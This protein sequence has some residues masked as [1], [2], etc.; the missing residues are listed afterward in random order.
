[1]S[2]NDP[3]DTMWAEACAMMERAERLHRQFFRPGSAAVAPATWEPP[4]DMFENEREVLI[5]AVLPGVAHQD[6]E[7]YVNANE[8]VLR[9]IRHMP[10]IGR[11]TAIRRLEVPY[12]RFERRVALTGASFRLQ[13]SELTNG[14]L[15]LSLLKQF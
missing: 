6:L 4:I 15:S 13:R 3:R 11:G 2:A 14:C 10:A 7:V 8:L 12:G 5:V 9:G 1:M